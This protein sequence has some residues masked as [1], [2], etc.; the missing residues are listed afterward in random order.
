[1]PCIINRDGTKVL[2]RILSG[3]DQRG[4]SG[5]MPMPLSGIDNRI[6]GA[7]VYGI[8]KSDITLVL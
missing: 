5:Q 8:F 1:M 4:R 7:H 2:R 3:A 6:N